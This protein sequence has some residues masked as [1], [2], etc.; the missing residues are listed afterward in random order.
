MEL[1][2]PKQFRLRT[3]SVRSSSHACPVQSNSFRETFELEIQ[4]TG[5]IL[6]QNVTNFDMTKYSYI[7]QW[8]L[9]S[10]TSLKGPEYC[11]VPT[12]TTLRPRGPK[13]ERLQIDYKYF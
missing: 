3:Q 4:R 13:S 9:D 1:R 8:P 7:G 10:I 2:P 5:S 6:Q 11:Q 12:V